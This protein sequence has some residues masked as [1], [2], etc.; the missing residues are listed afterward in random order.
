MEGKEKILNQLHFVHQSVC[1]YILLHRLSRLAWKNGVDFTGCQDNKLLD[2]SWH[3][4]IILAPLLG[5][6]I[7]VSTLF[8]FYTYHFSS[9]IASASSKK[10]QSSALMSYSRVRDKC[11][12]TF[13]N[14]W[15]SFQGL[16][17]YYGLNRPKFQYTSLHI[18]K[19]YI[20]TFC[21]TF[22]RL[23]L[24][25]GLCLFQTLEYLVNLCHVEKCLIW[26]QIQKMYKLILVKKLY[27]F[28]SSTF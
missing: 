9:P 22:R 20:Y 24:F 23:H 8:R 7:G 5:I 14:F 17:S 12:S 6:S 15:N 4:D 13:I 27:I 21:H 16:W 2:C 10:L 26:R 1:S 3:F 18:L 28:V 25:K 19:S 11:T